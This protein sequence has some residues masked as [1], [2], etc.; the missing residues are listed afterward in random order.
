MI[1]TITETTYSVQGGHFNDKGKH[2][3]DEC[4]ESFIRQHTPRQMRHRLHFIVDKQ[5]R[6]HHN[7]TWNQRVHSIK[8]YS[9]DYSLL[10]CLL[11]QT[12][13]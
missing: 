3:I 11:S 7:E 2:V 9:V 10:I 1:L 8:S 4:V 6:S 12:Y 13:P 5:L